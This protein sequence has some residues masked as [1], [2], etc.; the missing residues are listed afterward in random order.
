MHT[1]AKPFYFMRHAKTDWNDKQLY[2]GTKDIPINN[3]GQTQAERISYILQPEP[4]KVIITSPLS[5]AFSTAQIIGE[6]LKKPVIRME[7]FKQCCWGQN[8]GMCFDN[9][10]MIQQWL[11]GITPKGAESRI[12]FELRILSGLHQIFDKYENALIISHGGVYRAIRRLLS[13]SPIQLDHCTPHLHLPINSAKNK[14]SITE[15]THTLEK[16]IA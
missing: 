16:K 5:R 3:I 15:I 13:L 14:W 8:E 6:K 7:E 12:D 11:E 10:H 9:G 4:I 1:S 2:M